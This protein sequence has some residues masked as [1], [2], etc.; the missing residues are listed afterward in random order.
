M[1]DKCKRMQRSLTGTNNFSSLIGNA[2]NKYA[3]LADVTNQASARTNIG[4]LGSLTVDPTSS[5]NYLSLT[6]PF[7]GTTNT[8]ISVTANT[9]PTANSLV[10][11][12]SSGNISTSTSFCDTL[13]AYTSSGSISL[14]S[15]LAISQT[16]TFYITQQG[17]V[18]SGTQPYLTIIGSSGNVGIGSSTP[19]KKLD[20]AGSIRSTN[21]IYSDTLQANT[22][23]GAITTNSDIK[24]STANMHIKDSNGANAITFDGSGN[25]KFNTNITVP[26]FATLGGIL[27]PSL[28]TVLSFYSNPTTPTGA[29]T[30][31]SG[32]IFGKNLY[33]T[34]YSLT[35]NRTIASLIITNFTSLYTA[36]GAFL[37]TQ[38]SEVY[39][40]A[41]PFTYFN[42]TTLMCNCVISS[43]NNMGWIGSSITINVRLW[44]Y[45]IDPTVAFNSGSPIGSISFSPLVAGNF[46]N[47]LTLTGLTL[48]PNNMYFI[49]FGDITPHPSS[50]PTY[51]IGALEICLGNV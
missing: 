41:I 37:T 3:N 45:N 29:R 18:A 33:R 32:N 25:V 19:S 48:T 44:A 2:L 46:N 15:S 26:N 27:F 24:F 8:L 12:D 5:A 20:V 38:G 13:Q 11:Y 39:R 47:S 14:N 43:L 6:H 35:Y 28:S 51:T 9:I 1:Y 30:D 42:E 17:L 49:T 34:L 4:L 21:I 7:D 50:P 36:W 16:N 22:S 31:T 23:G 40:L 10:A